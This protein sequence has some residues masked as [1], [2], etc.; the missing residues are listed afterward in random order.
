MQ[1]ILKVS[2]YFIQLILAARVSYYR[3][4]VAA[5]TGNA[6]FPNSPVTLPDFTTQIDDVEAKAAVAAAA[7]TAL[8]LAEWELQEAAD[9]MDASARTIAGYVGSASMNNPATLESSGFSLTA[10][11]TPVGPMAP[12]TN[13]R[14]LPS[15]SGTS[16]L[17]WNRERGGLSWKVECAQNPMGP[18]TLIY[19]GS[20]ATCLATDLTPGT[21]YWFRVSVLGA[22]GWSDWSDP[23]SKRA[24]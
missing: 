23:I 22:A 11:P 3:N 12:P 4:V 17:K 18:W 16:L 10:P 14:A 20:R 19:N 7:K 15:L 24:V 6:A 5:L 21:Q 1:I 8:V 13:L 2:L 9:L